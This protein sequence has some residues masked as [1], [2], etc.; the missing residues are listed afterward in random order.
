MLPR[1][2]CMAKALECELNA[3]QIP[4]PAAAREWLRMASEWRLAA[5]G[6]LSAAGSGEH[7]PD[8]AHEFQRQEGLGQDR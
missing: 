8:V 6:A 2:F 4:D 3:G 1:A 7:A 5:T